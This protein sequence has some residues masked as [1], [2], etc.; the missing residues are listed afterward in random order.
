M[1]KLLPG[2]YMTVDVV[3]AA[4]M[5]YKQNGNKIEK[6]SYPVRPTND[7][8]NVDGIV[9]P[10]R[11]HINRILGNV[12]TIPSEMRVEAEA[13]ITYLKNSFLMSVLGGTAVTSFFKALHSAIENEVSGRSS[14]GVLMHAP[15]M[16]YTGLRHD[17][18]KEKTNENTF[19]SQVLG[20]VGDKISLDFVLLEKRYIQLMNCY[21]AYGHDGRGNLVSFLT[22][23]EKLVTDGKICAKV[24]NGGADRWHNNAIVT[25][26]NFVKVAE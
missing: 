10:N 15:S 16:Y 22:K 18:V 25:S 8:T 3:A 23:H 7:R 20:K 17:E 2:Q 9:V 1:S 5:A 11:D 26:L 19:T 6:Y 14:I 24:K 21:S 12:E 13:C 4:I